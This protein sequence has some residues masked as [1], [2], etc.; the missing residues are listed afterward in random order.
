VLT[1]PGRVTLLAGVCALTLVATAPSAAAQAGR[2]LPMRLPAGVVVDPAAPALPDGLMAS[3]WAVVDLDSG[4]VLAA[5]DAHAQHGPASTLKVLTAYALLPE[6]PADEVV[7]PEQSDIDVEGSKV[8]LLRGVPYPAEEL[9]AALLMASGNDTAN[10]LGTAAGGHTAAAVLMNR[11]ARKLGA[12]DTVAVNQHGL[13]AEGQVSTPYDLAVIGRAAL[14][15]PDIARW[16]T[17]PRATMAGKPGEPRFEI[18]NHNKLLGSYEGALGVKNG[19]TSRARASFVGAAERDGRRLL[20]T[21]M[22]AE[23]RVWAEAA[24]LLD[25]GFAAAAAGAAPVGVLPPAP[26]PVEQVAPI[27]QAVQTAVDAVADGAAS[28]TPAASRSDGDLTPLPGRELA[29]A[30]LVAAALVAVRPSR[31]S[32]GAAARTSAS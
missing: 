3:A 20:V 14:G 16:V 27:E 2:D 10:V 25:W 1:R 22:R 12:V 17:T 26:E 13:D 11:T 31:R 9:Y 32:P 8:G 4:Q 29:G 28:L 5:R 15:V 6:V 19:Y 7:V 21:L 24:L 30:L 18:Y 23:P